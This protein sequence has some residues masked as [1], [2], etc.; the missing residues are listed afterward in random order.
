MCPDLGSAWCHNHSHCQRNKEGQ[1][2]DGQR[3][4]ENERGRG[5]GRDRDGQRTDS[6]TGQTEKGEE[7][8]ERGM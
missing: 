3:E 8:K 1:G 2:R 4:K 7:E 6:V 5:K